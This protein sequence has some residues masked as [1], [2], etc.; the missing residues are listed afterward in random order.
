MERAS[1]LVAPAVGLLTILF[2]LV[3]L[4]QLIDAGVIDSYEVP[5]PSD[6]L[7]SI[8]RLFREEDLVARL[9]LTVGETAAAGVL[10]AAV[11]IPLGFLFYRL[12]QFND[13]FEPW[14]AASA[15]VP[16]V[17]AYPLFLV[18]FGRSPVSIVILSFAAGLAP[19]V[20]K[21]TEGFNSSPRVMVAV[22]RS[23]QL[24]EAQILRNIL[25]PAALPTVIL[26]MRL[27]LIFCL[28]NV[29]G[30]EFVTNIGGLGQLINQMSE[31]FDL[32]GT[33]AGIVLVVLVSVLFF[34]ILERVARWLQFAC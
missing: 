14:I 18:L 13:A 5:L 22:G 15:S 19:V 4:Q 20:L 27:G 11:G 1:R 8:P 17:L 10:I 3:L 7:A 21:T 32:P 33:Y 29:V 23:M 28:V 6:V 31:R 24:S 12:R 30:A 16:F 2:L 26:G 25:I 34:A 9:L